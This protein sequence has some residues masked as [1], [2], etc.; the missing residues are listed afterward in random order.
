MPQTPP[1][2]SGCPASGPPP[3]A[4]GGWTR[5]QEQAQA[6]MHSCVRA[7][8]RSYER[9]TSVYERLRAFGGKNF[10]DMKRNVRLE[11]MPGREVAGLQMHDGGGST[12]E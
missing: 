5:G 8:E 3:L 4:S 1:S 10:R 9:P 11:A 12:M 2:V 6:V 7:R